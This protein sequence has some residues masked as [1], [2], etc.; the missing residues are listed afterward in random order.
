MN[1]DAPGL[2]DAEGAWWGLLCNKLEGFKH[3]FNILMWGGG[4]G[5]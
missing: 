2:G 3:M 5:G 4:E 1:R